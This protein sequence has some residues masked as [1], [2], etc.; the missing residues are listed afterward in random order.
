MESHEEIENLA[1]LEKRVKIWPFLFKS[2]RFSFFLKWDLLL[3]NDIYS[4]EISFLECN[5]RVDD[6]TSL[7]TIEIL[8]LRSK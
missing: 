4:K 3:W 8:F 5:T 1:Y 7:Q 6:R 2:G